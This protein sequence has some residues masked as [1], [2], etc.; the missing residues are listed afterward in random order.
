MTEGHSHKSMAP[1]FS[2]I[3]PVYR[4]QESLIPLYERVKATLETELNADFELIMVNDASPD[5]AWRI[6]EGLAKRDS[7]VK[8][9]NFAR[10]FGQYYALTAG[11]DFA[12]GEWIVILDCDL[13]DQPEEIPKLYRKA[14]EGFD[15]VL[16]QRVDRQDTIIKKFFSNAFYKTF[17]YLTDSVQ[18]PSTAQF[19]IYHRNVVTTLTGMREK[20]RFLPAL[21]QWI[22]FKSTAIPV[23]HAQ[24]EHGQSSYS[25]AKLM[26]LAT[27]TIIAFS[28]KPLR[29]MIQSGFFFTGISFMAGI[30]LLVHRLCFG[31]YQAEGW[32]SL[33]ISMCFFSGLIMSMLGIIGIYI[34]KI[35]DEVKGRPLYIIRNT[36]GNLKVNPPE[37]SY[38]SYQ[39]NLPTSAYL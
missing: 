15:I 26:H 24:R 30:T 10:N 22:G 31:N 13:Q 16:A 7:R 21:I 29:L 2:I 5:N 37:T 9:I 19:G 25:F 23:E 39:P 36:A 20:L 27:D 18:D 11:L 12:Q 14:L 28:D 8:G 32:A 1:L 35:Y 33:I 3:T 6:I 38:V 17:S 4:S 34:S